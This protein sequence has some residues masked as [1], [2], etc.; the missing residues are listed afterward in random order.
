[1]EPPP[2]FTSIR[3]CIIRR[4][5]LAGAILNAVA[6]TPTRSGFRLGYAADN[7]SSLRDFLLDKG[8]SVD[9]LLEAGLIK[10]NEERNST[11]RHVPRAAD[12]PRSATARG[13]AIGFWRSGA[14]RRR[15]QVFEHFRN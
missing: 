5:R 15:A 1:M 3:S 12:L 10:R 4:Q 8:F 2:A 11:L 14:R 6:S 7:W 9:L 13:R